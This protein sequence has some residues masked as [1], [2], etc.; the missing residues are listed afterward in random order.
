MR[1]LI[2]SV[3]VLAALAF[4]SCRKE[5]T[6][7]CK[8]TVTTNGNGSTGEYSETADRV[9][10][11]EMKRGTGCYSLKSTETNSFGGQSYTTDV[12]RECE[13]D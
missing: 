8:V 11:R 3:T 2:L 6:C 12:V 7:T 1:T 5:R 13:L 9:T 10:K 4:T